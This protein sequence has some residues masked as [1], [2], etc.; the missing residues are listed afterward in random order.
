MV[1]LRR[2]RDSGFSLASAISYLFFT[3]C[4]CAGRHLLFFAAAKKSRQKKAA[5]TERLDAYPRALNVP[6][7]HTATF[8]LLFVASAL[9]KRV[10]C[11]HH[12]FNGTRQRVACAHLRQ[13]VCRLSRREARC[14]CP[15]TFRALTFV[16]RQPT[17]SL[18]QGGGDGLIAPALVR[19]CGAGEALSERAGNDGYAKRCRVKHGDVESPWVRTRVG[20]VSPLS[21]LT[22]FA[23]AKKVSAAPH[24]GN[25]R[26]TK[27]KRGCQRK[28]KSKGKK[29]RQNQKACRRQYPAIASITSASS[30]T[31][32][33]H[34]ISTA[35]CA[36]RH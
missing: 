30:P 15:K 16:M 25:A 23:A 21:L 34:R 7:F 32:V 2:S 31:A 3:R 10:T 22:F 26:S 27:A 20:G 24:R 9:N 1:C 33:E 29:Q 11:S 36:A 17:Q 5:H 6:V 12:F 35:G 4:P 14:S 19:V 28:S 13:T 8:W 18:P